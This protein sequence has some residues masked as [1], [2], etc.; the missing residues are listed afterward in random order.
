MRLFT[1]IRADFERTRLPLGL[2]QPQGSGQ[3][4]LDACNRASGLVVT[5][6]QGPLPFVAAH[7]GNDMNFVL[8]VIEDQ[9]RRKEE[10]DGVG[11]FDVVGTELRHARLDQTHHVITGVTDRAGRKRRQALGAHRMKLPG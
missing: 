4:S 5:P 8:D 7:I 6:A 1:H 11:H 10:K 3:R 2:G 9:H